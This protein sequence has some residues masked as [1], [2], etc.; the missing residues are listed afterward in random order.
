M[1]YVCLLV[2]ISACAGIAQDTVSLQEK[3]KADLAAATPAQRG[4]LGIPPAGE[5]LTPAGM[6]KAVV[7]D[8]NLTPAAFASHVEV[9]GV[10]SVQRLLHKVPKGA[11]KAFERAA[12]LSK[13]R[14]NAEAARELEQAIS[15]DPGFV[16]AYINLGAHYYLLNRLVDAERV[17]VRAIELDPSSATGHS[18][19]AA[20]ELLRGDLAGAE[21]YAKRALALSP[22]NERARRTLAAVYPGIEH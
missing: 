6:H 15:I 19:L 9:A 11:K 2:V 18:N 21:R 12:K 14:K 7:A 4:E 20:V 5:A 10:T 16:D 22:G 17:L 3:I 8:L 1:R 13:A